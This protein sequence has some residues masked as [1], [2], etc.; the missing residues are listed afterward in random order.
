[1]PPRH[2]VERSVDGLVREPHGIGH[3]SQCARN[4]GWTQASAKMIDHS[5][6]ELV[7]R[8]QF[9]DYARLDGQCPG[10]PISWNT[11][12]PSSDPGRTAMS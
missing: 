7:A 11:S 2:G 5:D 12:I 1:M 3:T 8:N 9:A 10:T 6:P 4:L